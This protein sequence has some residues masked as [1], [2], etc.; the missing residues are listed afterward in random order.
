MHRRT[1]GRAL[2]LLGCL[3]GPVALTT[4][5]STPLVDVTAGVTAERAPS[6]D[7]AL[8]LLR[9]GFADRATGPTTLVLRID[10]DVAGQVNVEPGQAPL[11]GSLAIAV[12]PGRHELDVALLTLAGTRRSNVTLSLDAGVVVPL[13]L[14][15]AGA[16]Q[17]QE[18]VR[19]GG[20]TLATV[21]RHDVG[22]GQARTP[23]LGDDAVAALAAMLADPAVAVVTPA[24]CEPGPVDALGPLVATPVP[25]LAGDAREPPYA[26]WSYYSFCSC[27]KP[28]P[29]RPLTLTTDGG[30]TLQLETDRFG[31]TLLR[32]RTIASLS[33]GE[34]QRPRPRSY[35]YVAGEADSRGAALRALASG[36][37]GEMLTALLDIAADPQ[38][39][40][41]PQ[42][43]S[44]LDAD[45]PVVWRMAALALGEFAQVGASAA[46]EREAAHRVA[47]LGAGVDVQ[48]QIFV[49]GAL[50]RPSS[51]PA[52]IAAAGSA[53]PGARA[54]AAW[55]LGFV[56]DDAGLPALM[57]LAEDAEPSVRRDAV[58]GLA[59][60]GDARAAGALRR[61]AADTDADVRRLAEHAGTW[62]RR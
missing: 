55:A 40:L 8:L 34:G 54:D 13:D 56:A 7:T 25:T 24:A 60:L 21:D 33:Y 51:L 20:D 41:R 30:Q 35:S 9:P 46:L 17:I 22:R 23:A 12:A 27:G 47:L 19:P 29:Q 1:S 62:L 36:V 15:E 18:A 42:L 16:L 14:D 4:C 32:E 61:L 58:V 26:E 6:L 57:R 2:L 52:L 37:P 5:E 48:R 3:L 28:V 59:R 44:L 11:E 53:A 10:G 43:M 31:L 45:D 38:A 49:L 50:R 39:A